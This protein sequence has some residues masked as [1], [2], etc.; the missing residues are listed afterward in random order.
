MEKR[1]MLVKVCGMREAENIA[2][3]EALGIDLMGFI[4]WS[5]SPR[6]LTE[7][8]KHLPAACRRVGVFVNASVQEIVEQV[9]ALGFNAIQLHGNET[10]DFCRELR[11]LPALQGVELFK[12]FRI[13]E[14]KDLEACDAYADS[15]S[16]YVF[17]TKCACYGGSGEQFDWSV[18]EQYHTNV[19]FLLSGGI[20]PESVEALAAFR[21]PMWRG[22]DLNSRF[23]TA[24]GHKDIEKL[25]EFIS[26]FRQLK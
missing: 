3:V 13:A 6:A 4:C 23:E 22:V 18:L 15:C 10:P 8:P 2:G 20:G 21:H 16:L 7:V 5:K 11:G 1:D 12:A 19:P 26:R 24:P 17:D 14:A 25:R 9:G